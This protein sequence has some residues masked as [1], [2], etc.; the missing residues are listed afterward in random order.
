MYIHARQYKDKEMKMSYMKPEM[1]RSPKAMLSDLKVLMDKGEGKWSLAEVVWEGYKRLAVRWNGSSNDKNHSVGT[2][3]SR[4]LP[5]WFI[6]PDDAEFIKLI[7]DWM[8]KSQK[9]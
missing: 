2:P 4:G 3:Q 8:K 1:V 7:N 5:M 9:K 6:L